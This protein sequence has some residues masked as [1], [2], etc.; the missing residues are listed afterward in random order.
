MNEGMNIL[1]DTS[2]FTLVIILLAGVV[3]GKISKLIKI[4]EVVVYLIF[5]VILGHQGL[6]I[7]DIAESSFVNQIVLIYGAAFIIY[8]GGREIK[9]K[10]LNEVKI[11][12]IL[13]ATV[14]VLISTSIV[15]FFAKVIFG[16]DTVTCLLIGAVI[17][18]TDPASLIPVFSKVSIKKSLKNTVIAESAFNDA[19]GT[20]LIITIVSIITGAKFDIANI[21]GKLLE[22]IVLGGAIGFSI[23]IIFSYLIGHH[24][25]LFSDYTAIIS[26]IVSMSAYAIADYFGGS[27]F[28]ATFVAGLICGNKKSFGLWVPEK[29]YTISSNFRSV[30]E[31][32]IKIGIFIL[33]GSHVDFIA[34][35]EFFVPSL[36]IVLVLVII[37]RPVS[38][39][40]CTIFDRKN[41]WSWREKVFMSWIRE[42]GV[43]PA[44]MSS[45]IVSMNIPHGKLISSIVFMAIIITLG[46]QSS[47]TEKMVKILKLEE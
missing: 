36:V 33:L 22:M 31:E 14:G 19:V 4:P 28:M 12:V 6:G 17:A 39:F 40:V 13:L 3:G 8:C 34:L 21:S 20:V 44:A 29:D 18:S 25:A 30:I 26:L 35:K 27:G 38:V 41:K 24:K 32:L 46:L 43:I 5:G 47:L 9:L 23:G 2:L 16:L 10:E 37:A 11:S 42:T 15:A 45:V 7:V 1:I